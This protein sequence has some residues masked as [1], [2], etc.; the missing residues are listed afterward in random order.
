[1]LVLGFMLVLDLPTLRYMGHVWS[2]F[3]AHTTHALTTNL[4]WEK[5]W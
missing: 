5:L 1:M 3:V 4:M 2:I